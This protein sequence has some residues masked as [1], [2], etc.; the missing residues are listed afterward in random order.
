MP[1][2]APR[3]DM[4]PYAAGMAK[5]PPVCRKR[6][7]LAE[8]VVVLATRREGRG[9]QLIAPYTRAVAR[10]EIH[11]LIVTDEP[12]AAPGRAVNDVAYLGFAEILQGGVIIVGDSVTI[13]DRFVGVIAGFDEAHMPNHQNV[14]IRV[15]ERRS[16][17]ELD[18]QCGDGVVIG[19]RRDG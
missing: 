17:F 12:N 11:E 16:G 2:A 19:S 4:D 14:L 5:G 6:D 3:S 7:V 15:S 18:L 13:G 10:D 8:M 9:L 1:S